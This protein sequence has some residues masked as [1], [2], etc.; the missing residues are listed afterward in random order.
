MRLFGSSSPSF[1]ILLS[2]D[3]ARGWL[4]QNGR[5][6]LA[7]LAKRVSKIKSLL[8]E[9]CFPQPEEGS[10]CD[11]LR[12]AFAI[13]DNIDA[14]AFL[15]TQGIEPEYAGHGTVILIPAP[16]NG[17]EAFDRLQ[18]ALKKLGRAAKPFSGHFSRITIY[19]PERIMFPRDA[20][21]SKKRVVPVEEALGKVSAMNVIPCPPAVPVVLAGEEIDS[22]VIALLKKAGKSKI[23]IVCTG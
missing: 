9:L 17:E 6:E 4:E 13:P 8:K 10:G 15:R 20:F 3:C 14:G 22:G 5:A 21:M 23:Q 16:T 2:L 12:I 11:P 7:L 1:P 19:T 18:I